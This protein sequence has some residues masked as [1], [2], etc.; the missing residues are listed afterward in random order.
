MMFAAWRQPNEGGSSDFKLKSRGHN[1]A[2]AIGFGSDL[3]LLYNDAALAADG[4]QK[5]SC[6][7]PLT[8]DMIATPKR[9]RLRSIRRRPPP[10][11][12][13]FYDRQVDLM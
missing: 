12:E 6:R 11:L 3:N 5:D 9:V 10:R 2:N 13:F 4:R 1:D 7:A 8:E